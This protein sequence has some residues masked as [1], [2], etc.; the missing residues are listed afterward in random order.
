MGLLPDGAD[1]SEVQRNKSIPR[2]VSFVSPQSFSSGL[3][4]M[5]FNFFDV[6]G[7]KGSLKIESEA[8]IC[9]EIFRI[10]FT[11]FS[12]DL[13]IFH[14]SQS[15]RYLFPNLARFI[16]SLRASLKRN[17]FIESAIFVGNNSRDDII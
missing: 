14:G 7:R 6:K 8:V 9:N 5:L 16:I 4:K 3:K 13:T 15:A 2:E 10:V 17:L 1:A 12:S 11:L